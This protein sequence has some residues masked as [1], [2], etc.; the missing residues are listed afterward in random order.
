MEKKVDAK[1]KRRIN[2]L[3]GLKAGVEAAVPIVGSTI[4]IGV[5][6]AWANKLKKKKLVVIFFGDGATEEGV[7][8]ES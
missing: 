1:R 4:P 5:G 2:A 3:N 8:Y 7:F 6:K